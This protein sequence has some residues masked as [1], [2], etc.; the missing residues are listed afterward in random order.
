MNT[1]ETEKLTFHLNIDGKDTTFVIDYGKVN[2][3]DEVEIEIER[4]AGSSLGRYVLS[5]S[6]V[7]VEN[8][9]GSGSG[10]GSNGGT[11][12][13]NPNTGAED[14]VG[15]VAAMAVVSMAAGAALMLKKRK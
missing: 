9:P 8:K 2:L 1:D 7:V 3:Y 12:E 11:G 5:G 4:K 6:K 13:S 14:M 15:V 10:S